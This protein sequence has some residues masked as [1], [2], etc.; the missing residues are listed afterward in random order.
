MYFPIVIIFWVLL[1][2]AFLA[3]LLHAKTLAHELILAT[4][5]WYFTFAFLLVLW[6]GWWETGCPS[7]DLPQIIIWPFCPTPLDDR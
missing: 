2:C 1:V 6:S 3:F 5:G 7:R 4:A